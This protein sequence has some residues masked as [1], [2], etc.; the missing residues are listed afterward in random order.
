MKKIYILGIFVLAGFLLAGQVL[1][2]LTSPR[3]ACVYYKAAYPTGHIERNIDNSCLIRV[4]DS[5]TGFG[6]IHAHYV[7][8]KFCLDSSG[9]FFG[10]ADYFS[11]SCSPKLHPEQ[12]LQQPAAPSQVPAAPAFKIRELQYDHLPS[13]KPIT[14]EGN[15]LIE[16]TMPDGSRIQLDANSTFTPV[17]DHEVQ[18]VFG[19]YRYMWQPFKNG[20]CIVGQNLVRQECR[21]VKTRDAIL[22]ITGTEFLVDTDKSG[23]TV[24][25]LEGSLSVADLNVKKTVEV[26]AGQFTYIKHGGLPSDPAPYDPEKIEPWW[27]QTNTE[28]AVR[29]VM[30]LIL[31]FVA[32][33]IISSLIVSGKRLFANRRKNKK[34]ANQAANDGPI[35]ASLSFGIL[36]LILG[37]S[38]F[39]IFRPIPR[40]LS[41]FLRFFQPGIHALTAQTN[42][43]LFFLI[44]GVVGAILGLSGLR[45]SN[46]IL[47]ALSILLNLG[48]ILIWLQ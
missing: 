9:L 29:N 5:N 33:I 11:S 36:N 26:A 43:D 41:E 34:D 47:A 4:G 48:A 17:S 6:Y 39:L 37:L 45:T 27:L 20:K 23:T 40:I 16:I 35:I 18:S 42:S 25:V 24:S 10:R 15:E 13:G 1:A 12:Q 2:Q 19:R 44:I 7:G 21:K 30:S 32:V 3:E 22:G 31:A 38:N 28:R 14:S 8:D 46:K